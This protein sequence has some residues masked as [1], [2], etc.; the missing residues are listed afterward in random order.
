[1]NNAVAR[2]YRMKVL[3]DYY[4]S[5]SDDEK[6]EMVECIN[7]STKVPQMPQNEP[8]NGHSFGVGVLENIVGNA[9]W[10]IPV[11]LLKRVLRL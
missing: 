7:K 1:M 11:W 6:R 5:L 4:E 8:K 9:A 2:Y 3:V 10:D